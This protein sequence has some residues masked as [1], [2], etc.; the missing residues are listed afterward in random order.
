MLVRTLAA[1]FWYSY[2]CCLTGFT[3]GKPVN[4]FILAIFFRRQEAYF[5]ISLMWLL[6][7]RSESIITLDLLF[8]KVRTD[9]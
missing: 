2:C 6:E 4:L 3:E 7:I 8:L 9:F 1:V 5:V